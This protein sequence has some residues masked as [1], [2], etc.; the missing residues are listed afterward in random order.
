MLLQPAVPTAPVGVTGESVM[1]G[2]ENINLE[3][4]LASMYR[5]LLRHREEMDDY[6]FSFYYYYLIIMFVLL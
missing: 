5:H 4:E 2:V 6:P 1:G 3:K